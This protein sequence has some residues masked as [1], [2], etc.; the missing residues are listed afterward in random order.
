MSQPTV[1]TRLLP[2]VHPDIHYPVVAAW[3]S[4]GP[5][6]EL[7]QQKITSSLDIWLA[8]WRSGS[9]SVAA[10][11]LKRAPSILSSGLGRLACLL[12]LQS[13]YCLLFRDCSPHSISSAS[14][15]ALA[16]AFV[17]CLSYHSLVCSLL[18]FL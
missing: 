8:F 9:N 7:G 10:S 14:L 18:A 4:G 1:D 12:I 13:L 3:G 15:Q 6:T 2:L 16:S 17:A 11:T 5:L